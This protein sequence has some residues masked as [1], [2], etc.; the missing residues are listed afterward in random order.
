V[1]QLFLRLVITMLVIATALACAAPQPASSGRGSS[2]AVPL[3]LT[4]STVE[5]RAQHQDE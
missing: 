3:L 1:R 5:L 4:D 2:D